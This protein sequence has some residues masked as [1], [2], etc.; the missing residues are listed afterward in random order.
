MTLIKSESNVPWGSLLENEFIPPIDDT[1]SAE[2]MTNQTAQPPTSTLGSEMEEC[3]F[4]DG[5]TQ[6]EYFIGT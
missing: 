5:F 1:T 2:G 3:D 4:G 6:S